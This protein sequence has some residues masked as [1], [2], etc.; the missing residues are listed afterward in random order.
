MLCLEK[1]I[2]RIKEIRDIHKGKRC[3]VIGTGPSLNKTDFSLLKNEILFGVNNLYAGYDKFKISP[4]YY[5]VSDRVVWERHYER[6]LRLDTTLFIWDCVDINFI[7]KNRKDIISIHRL[8]SISDNTPL[9][10]DITRGTNWGRTVILDLCLPI[11]YY[12]G[13]E[14]VY[15]LGCDCDYSGLH[16]FDGSRTECVACGAIGDWEEIFDLYKRYKKV[17]EDN[18]REIINSTVEGKLEI[19]KRESL[20]DIIN[21]N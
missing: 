19:F 5:V 13:F 7:P 16:R 18:G 4:Q 2:D 3:F 20:E 10:L 9:S 14:E 15:L 6:I 8:D 1:N 12:M 17:Y 21:E 11:C